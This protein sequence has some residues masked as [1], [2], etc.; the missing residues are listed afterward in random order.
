[1]EK[2]LQILRRGWDTC[3][4]HT[5]A[6]AWIVC[7][8]GFFFTLF[9]RV[10][11]V[12]TVNFDLPEP[13]PVSKDSNFVLPELGP[14]KPSDLLDRPFLFEVSGN[15]K[16]GAREREYQLQARYQSIC[17]K[18]D[19]SHVPSVTVLEES[20]LMV[21]KIENEPFVM[22]MAEDCPSYHSR[23]S[24]EQKLLLEREVAQGW[25]LILEQDLRRQSV[26]RHPAYLSL[27]N[28]LASLVFF[29]VGMA[30][31]TLSWMSR[32]FFRHPLWSL[33]AL[34]WVSYLSVLAR[35][36][37]SLGWLADFLSQG[38]LRPLYAFVCC[39][40][41]VGLCQL[42]TQ[43]SLQRYFR[44][45]AEY[46]GLPANQRTH[47]RRATLQQAA[48]FLARVFWSILGVGLFGYF[49]G[50]EFSQFFAGA[51]LI[52]V[53]IGVI[54]RDILLDLFSGFNIISE[55]QFGV[56]DW[57]ESQSDSGEVVAFSLR[58]TQIRRS[59][60]SLV[61][62]PNSDLRRV[63]NH[64]NQWSQVD[65]QVSIAYQADHQRALQALEQEA[66]ELA[67]A[68][69]DKVVAPPSLLGIQSL[70]LDGVVLR[71]FLRTVPLAQ[72]EIQRALHARVKERFNRDEIEFASRRISLPSPS[73]PAGTKS[74]DAKRLPM[75]TQTIA[76]MIQ[77]GIPDAIVDVRDPL[78]DRTHF[79]AT[80]VSPSFEGKSRVQQHKMVYAALGESF[81]GP[82]HALQLTTLTPADA[83]KK[84]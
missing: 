8:V 78:Q 39:F 34:L 72:W 7:L 43:L 26:K 29:L 65:Y 5:T 82:L 35:L 19:G 13:T 23:L 44:A 33:K 53:A 46:D 57:I 17:A 45:L 66:R 18:L 40:V 74:V 54:A 3:S 24:D 6:V 79:E 11:D 21:I 76:Q 36:H 22:V 62:I 47:Q 31:L 71:L 58:A 15:D 51:G 59:D 81:S 32:R 1:M 25:R 73:D 84:S 2:A 9:G 27:Y 30:H 75:E 55:D 20:R 83:A 49:L 69:P 38:A 50:L 80:V 48:V 64:S 68:F 37:P 67:Q 70:T 28:Y 10:P 77:A 61:T 14:R 4:R 12:G 42:L 41:V 52:G 56:G 63:R 60:G 16:L